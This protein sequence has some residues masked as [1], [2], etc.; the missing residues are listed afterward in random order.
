MG[1]FTV[2]V[3]VSQAPHPGIR[4]LHR[5]DLRFRLQHSGP[6]GHRSQRKR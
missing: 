5:P 2:C 4:A 3:C 6:A 1:Y